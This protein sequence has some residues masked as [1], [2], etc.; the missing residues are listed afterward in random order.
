MLL[1]ISINSKSK[2]PWLTVYSCKY[3]SLR[4]LI[5]GETR[6][7]RREKNLEKIFSHY[8]GFIINAGILFQYVLAY[9]RLA[10]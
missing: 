10:L 5:F 4:K 7:K 3:K 6:I 9:L 1:I 8:S 2:K